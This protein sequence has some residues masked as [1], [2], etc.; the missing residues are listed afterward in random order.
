MGAYFSSTGWS[1]RAE[2]KQHR[3]LSGLSALA[4]VLPLTYRSNKYIRVDVPLVA[5]IHRSCQLVAV[6]IALAQLYFEDGWAMAEEPGGMA[7][8]WVETGNMLVA[9]DDTTLSA[10][11]PYCSNPSYSYV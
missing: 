8:A 10:R 9:T 3:G 1:A 6:L 5:V 2:N 11:T 7:N 4:T